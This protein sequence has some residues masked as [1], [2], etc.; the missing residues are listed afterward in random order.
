MQQLLV[1]IWATNFILNYLII[2]V[3]AILFNCYVLVIIGLYRG[4]FNTDATKKPIGAATDAIFFSALLTF[5]FNKV[6]H[7]IME[8]YTIQRVEKI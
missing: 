7:V 5:V 4:F 6:C 2:L 8:R 1:K 3:F